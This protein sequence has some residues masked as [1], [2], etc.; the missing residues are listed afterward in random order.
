MLVRVL[1]HYYPFI[2]QNTSP[3]TKPV[4]SLLDLLNELLLD[5]TMNLS[6]ERD[7]Y[8]FAIANRYLH[9]LLKTPLYRLNI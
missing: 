5:I 9:A 3:G 8:A 2:A 4:M 1:V 6:S 7:V